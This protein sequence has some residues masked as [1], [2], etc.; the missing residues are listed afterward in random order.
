MSHLFHYLST[1]YPPTI[2]S[3]NKLIRLSLS[4][5]AEVIW[6]YTPIAASC[7]AFSCVTTLNYRIIARCPY[8]HQ[9]LAKQDELH[10]VSL[11]AT[12]CSTLSNSLGRSHPRIRA[13]I[14]LNRLNSSHL[15]LSPDSPCRLSLCM[16]SNSRL[17]DRTI[18]MGLELVFELA[19]TLGAST[20][21]GSGSHKANKE[22]HP[23]AIHMARGEDL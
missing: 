21:I 11:L 22:R 7:P 10:A 14:E 8:W 18:I 4:R 23:H 3:L 16:V 17:T 15:S 12:T 5:F 20:S 13:F 1:K 19:E 6:Q 9:P 2:P